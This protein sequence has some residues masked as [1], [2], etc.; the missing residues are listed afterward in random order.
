M[1][2]AER[3][4]AILLNE[5]DLLSPDDAEL[6]RDIAT[7]DAKDFVTAHNAANAKKVDDY[8]V[9]YHGIMVS[10]YY[11]GCGTCYTRFES[12]YTGVGDNAYEALEDAMSM[13]AEDGWDV[14]AIKN[15]NDPN[16]P[17]VA[18]ELEANGESSDD[19]GADI[20]YYVCLRVKGPEPIVIESEGEHEEMMSYMLPEIERLTTYRKLEV[21]E[22]VSNG[23]FDYVTL[24]LR[25][26]AK[27]K[28]IHYDGYE[29]FIRHNQEPMEA[30][31]M[32]VEM[33]S[34]GEDVGEQGDDVVAAHEAVE[35]LWDTLL[36]LFNEKYVPFGTF[37][38]SNSG[39]GSCYGCW[40][41]SDYLRD[42]VEDETIIELE[43]VG[44]KFPDK[45]RPRDTHQWM[46]SPS[47]HQAMYSPEGALL[48]K[49]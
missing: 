42:S 24:C 25:G 31:N 11:Q 5:E 34:K 9:G 39:C 27:L 41:A 19:G 30:L 10:D 6:I 23:T 47:G 26:L 33:H 2:H 40:P 16:E 21:G 15:D 46:T 32:I 44:T 13:A 22:E 3:I 38:G 20:Y 12:A 35:S 49:Y 48:W 36:E 28:E 8:D 45:V 37:F 17:G 18:A 29:G 4:V 43:T 14:S 7:A 1:T